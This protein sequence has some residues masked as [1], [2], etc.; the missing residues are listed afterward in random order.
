MRARTSERDA[1]NLEPRLSRSL[2]LE[3]LVRSRRPIGA[4][5]SHDLTVHRRLKHAGAHEGHALP[6]PTMT[7]GAVCTLS[8]LFRFR[9][10]LGRRVSA[11]SG[12]CSPRPRACAGRSPAFDAGQDF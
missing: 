6:A 11:P 3:Q 9:R 2:C 8:L 10:A 7:A 12:G 1:G 4:E 5:A